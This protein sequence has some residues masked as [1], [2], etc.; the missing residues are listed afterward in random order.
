MLLCVYA[1]VCHSKF[2]YQFHITEASTTSSLPRCLTV[3]AFELEQ[4][5]FLDASTITIKIEK[6]GHT[7][8]ESV[9]A[10]DYCVFVSMCV[11]FFCVCTV[12]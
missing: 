6:A 3:R 11:A 9:P 8:F 1:C 5:C 12:N 2:P 7:M 4:F 10:K